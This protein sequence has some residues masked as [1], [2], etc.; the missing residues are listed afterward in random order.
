MF[1]EELLDGFAVTYSHER[2]LE[3]DRCPDFSKRFCDQLLFAL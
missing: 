3:P 2:R 1:I